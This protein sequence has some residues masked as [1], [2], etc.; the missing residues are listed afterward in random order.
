MSRKI[1]V[2]KNGEDEVI[3]VGVETYDQMIESL[4][5]DAEIYNRDNVNQMIIEDVPDDVY[6]IYD[7]GKITSAEHHEMV[8]YTHIVPSDE[9]D[10][11]IQ[12]GID[13]LHFDGN[14]LSVK[15][16]AVKTRKLEEISLLFDITI[17]SGSFY[18]EAVGIVVDCRRSGAK[19]DYQNIISL[20]SRMRRNK[21]KSVDYVGFSETK[22]AT[23]EQI[24]SLSYEIEDRIS[25]LYEKKWGYE[26]AV[27]SSVTRADVENIAISF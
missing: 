2:S 12:Y 16:E 4:K 20:L 6:V 8:G 21:I 17:S 22:N 13:N 15:L 10:S 9:W 7:N 26:S 11:M 19:N 5:L 25:T 14:T 3:V 18:S 27:E 24:E 23:Y 1:K